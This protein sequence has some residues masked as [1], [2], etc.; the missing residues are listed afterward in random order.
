MSAPAFFSLPISCDSAL[1]C[2][3]SFS[4][5][6]SAARRWLSSSRNASMSS[7]NPRSASRAAMEP[8][9]FRKYPRSYMAAALARSAI[10]THFCPTAGP[11]YSARGR[12]SRLLA[13]CSRMC[14]VQPDMRLTAKIG[15]NRS[16]GI[17][18][19]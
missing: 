15:V 9:L 1:R 5:S 11:R 17:P 14:A 2:A 10:G 12:I 6:A 8:I 16:T 7:V 4:D 13:Y 18:S 19:E 3:F